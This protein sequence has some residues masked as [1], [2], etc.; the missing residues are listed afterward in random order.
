VQPRHYPDA[1]RASVFEAIPA[2][3]PPRLMLHQNTRG[4]ASCDSSAIRGSRGRTI[5]STELWILRA[6]V[7][8]QHR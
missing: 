2:D 1:V 5:E 3:P 7:L 4:H 8:N 6:D